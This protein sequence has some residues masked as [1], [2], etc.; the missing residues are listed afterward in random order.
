MRITNEGHIPAPIYRAICYQWY[1]GSDDFISATQLLQPVRMI[2]L[3]KRHQVVT[4]ASDLIWSLMGSAMHQVLEKTETENTLI[5]ERLQ[6]EIGD[7]ILSGGIDL[8]EN[9]VITDFKFTSVYSYLYGSRRK[10]YER[11]LNIYSLLYQNAGFSV[12]KLRIIAIFRDWSRIKYEVE[13][14]YPPQVISIP[15]RKWPVS[16]TKEFV[17][18]RIRQ[19][20][21]AMTLSDGDLPLCTPHD[22]WQAPATFAVRKEGNKRALRVFETKAQAE[23]FISFHKDKKKLSI[24]RRESIPKRCL[25]YCPVSDFCDFYKNYSLA[26]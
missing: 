10:D 25:H 8:Y 12:K 11:Q 9:E 23:K 7:K 4:D 21:Y 15:I 3:G 20:E 5:E 26:A 16:M 6:M 18:R 19:I 13:S 22:R 14:N 17:T 24:E 2:V 1:K